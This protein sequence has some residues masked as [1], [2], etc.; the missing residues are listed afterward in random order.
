MI[1]YNNMV[2]EA[3]KTFLG[4]PIK[5]PEV[6]NPRETIKISED[7]GRWNMWGLFAYKVGP[8]VEMEYTVESPDRVTGKMAVSGVFNTAVRDL[9]PYERERIDREDIFTSKL[10]GTYKVSWK[11]KP[12]TPQ[13]TA[14]EV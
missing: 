10:M 2:I 1:A 3:R 13:P 9:G 6:I 7:L 14:S 4:I 5:R 8:Y 11:W 12:E